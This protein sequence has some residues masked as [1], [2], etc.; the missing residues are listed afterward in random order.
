ML[1]LRHGRSLHQRIQPG[2][3]LPVARYSVASEVLGTVG[4]WEEVPEGG[5]VGVGPD[6]RPI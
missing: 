4:P 6:L 3:G 2:E 5:L 1:A